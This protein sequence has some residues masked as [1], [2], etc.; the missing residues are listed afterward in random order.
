[1]AL[2]QLRPCVTENVDRVVAGP[3]E[4]VGDELDQGRVRPLQVFEEQHHGSGLRH[5]LEEKPPG[6]EELLLA[7]SSAFVDPEQMRKS[8]LDESSLLRIRNVLLDRRP[9]LPARPSGSSPSVIC[10]RMRTISAS[11]QNAT[12]SP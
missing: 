7:V 4:E 1:M 12:P 10:A 8:G 2:L 5:A 6:A 9:H 11:A 3:L